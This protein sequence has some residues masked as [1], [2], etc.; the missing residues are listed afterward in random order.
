MFRLLPIK[1]VLLLSFCFALQL[2]AENKQVV[3][4]IHVSNN[5]S[6]FKYNYLYNNQAQ[7]VVET[8]TL[9][10]GTT[11]ENISQTEWFRQADLHA[12][13]VERI[14]ADN[15]W[16][17]RYSIRYQ[18]IDAKIIE[19]HFVIENNIETE[20]R[21]IEF[22][23]TNNL[24]TTQ[25]EYSKAN[26][27]WNKV[28]ETTFFYSS[29]NLTDSTIVI[30]YE[31]GTLKSSYKT[32]Y[33][34][35]PNASLKS[36]IVQVKNDFELMYINVSKSVYSYKANAIESLRNYSWN[37]KSSIWENDTK[38]EYLYD[39]TG[40]I[41][42]EISWQWNSMYWQQVLRY[43]YLYDTKNQL[44]KKLVSTP[45]YRD[46][47][48]TNSVNYLR[49][50]DSHNMTI[51][52]V[53]GFWGGKAGDK[54]NTHIAFP[55]NDETIIRKAETIQLSYVPFIESA[56]TVNNASQP[57]LVRVYPNPSHGV[58]YISNFE[59]SNS[60]WTLSGLNGTVYKN[61]GSNINSSVIDISE[62]PNG[63]YLLNIRSASEIGTHK[64]VKY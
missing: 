19:T 36:I 58:F 64:I 43:N 18:Q 54:L 7:P 2:S 10:N 46:W 17:G 31:N 11:W 32:D 33:N 47:R 30:R 38:L 14:W 15:K 9:K 24:K 21:K 52:S 6:I 28:L 27:N 22:A 56:V 59:A 57:S 42:D 60:T 51:E 5:D 48:N 34:Y 13:Q 26:N 49:Q 20:I 63:I 44:Y 16:N 40:N 55:F 8:K 29:N 61:S 45:I 3:A 35:Y 62:L 12:G 41:Q 23:S 25:T 1:I 50:P 53:Y 39:A 37:S 4:E